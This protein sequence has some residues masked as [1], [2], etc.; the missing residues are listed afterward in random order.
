MLLI[1][2]QADQAINLVKNQLNQPNIPD[3]TALQLL[4]GEIYTYQGKT[5]D[6]ITVYNQAI[7]LNKDDFRPV[8]A[9]AILLQQQ[10]NP[11]ADILFQQAV[12]LAPVQYKDQI[13]ELNNL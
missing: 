10:E 6:A 1:Q 7:T 11:S 4:L 12:E 8:L 3:K 9:K 2:E 13:K 5:E